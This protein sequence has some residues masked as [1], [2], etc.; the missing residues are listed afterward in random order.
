VGLAKLRFA[1][2][3]STVVDN[4]LYQSQLNDVANWI[5]AAAFVQNLT[6]ALALFSTP[7]F[8]QAVVDASGKWVFWPLAVGIF[9]YFMLEVGCWCAEVQVGL[10]P[11]RWVPLVLLSGRLLIVLGSAMAFGL[12][13]LQV[14]QA[15]R[16]ASEAQPP[17]GS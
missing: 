11:P 4:H 16:R 2:V 1:G 14:R 17:S 12:S 3:Q 10:P 9:A 6:F 15:A 5:A 13:A 8:R 7:A